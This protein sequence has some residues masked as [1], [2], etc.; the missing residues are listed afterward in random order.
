MSTRVKVI[1]GV[2][3]HLPR[4]PPCR[5]HDR[6]MLRCP[7]CELHRQYLNKKKTFDSLLKK[8]LDAAEGNV[9]VELDGEEILTR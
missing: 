5:D 3:D 1:L 4:A 7:A 6:A 2:M 9:N 8:L